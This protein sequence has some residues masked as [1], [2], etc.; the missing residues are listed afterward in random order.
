ML[1]QRLFPLLSGIYSLTKSKVLVSNVTFKDGQD[2]IIY[3]VLCLY[4]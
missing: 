1:P 2:S 3:I 4:V